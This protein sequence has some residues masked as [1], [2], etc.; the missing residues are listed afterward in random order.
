[1][2]NKEQSAFWDFSLQFYDTPE[3]QQA[4]L[5]LQDAHGADVNIALFLLFQASLGQGLSDA[6][7]RS[8][9]QEIAGWRNEV[10][11]S[12]RVLRRRLKQHPFALAPAA[13]ETFRNQIKQIELQSEK[14][15]QLHLETIK[16]DADRMP[17]NQAAQANMEIYARHLDVNPNNAS[18]AV[19]QDRF[20]HL[21]GQD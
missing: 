5:N 4:C 13:Q 21:Y 17:R 8:L 11:R 3:V 10:V 19:L 1:M 2:T 9:D 14:L 6:T 12:L 15:Q 7:V 20:N 16:I 18:L